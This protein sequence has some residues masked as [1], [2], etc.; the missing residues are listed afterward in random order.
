MKT[1]TNDPKPSWLLQ[2]KSLWGASHYPFQDLS[3]D[4]SYTD[5][6]REDTRH[7]IEQMLC[8]GC[9]GML[10][11]PNG[12]GKSHLLL[13]LRQKLHGYG[14]QVLLHSHA[15]LRPNSLIRSI[16]CEFGITAKSRKEDN[17]QGIHHYCEQ[18]IPQPVVLIFDEAANLAQETLEEIRLL[19]CHLGAEE[20]TQ[21]SLPILLC[22]DENLYPRLSLRYFKPLLSRLSFQ[23]K[24]HRLTCEQTHQYIRH[25]LEQAH[26]HSP[27]FDSGT[28]D[29]IHEV[30]QGT[31]RTINTLCLQVIAMACEQNKPKITSQMLEEVIEE[32]PWLQILQN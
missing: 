10:T 30:S 18:Q 14:A 24:V 19:K 4:E 21:Y 6:Q 28:I 31:P 32:I 16:C 29:S 20:Q 11:G 5:Q 3:I 13:Q 23:R 7:K 17:I 2:A 27:L 1:K 25:H 9:S 26:I 8:L 15:T 22:G 12:S